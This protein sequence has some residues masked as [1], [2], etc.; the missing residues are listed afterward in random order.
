VIDSLTPRERQVLQL[1]AAGRTTKQFASELGIS[2]KTAACHRQRV[3]EKI[4][5]ANTAELVGRAVQKGWITAPPAGLSDEAG[6]SGPLEPL[7]DAGR[8]RRS[9]E[10]RRKYRKLLAETVSKARA[11][12]GQCKAAAD[13]LRDTRIATRDQCHEIFVRT[14][15]LTGT[16]R[17]FP[18]AARK[19]T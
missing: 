6:H 12:R 14:Q 9:I 1:I 3:L 13:E 8:L 7:M 16:V 19:A 4:G 18:K 5:A 11:L 2:F 15:E 17:P 10:E